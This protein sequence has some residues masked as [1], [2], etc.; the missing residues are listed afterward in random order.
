VNA[1]SGPMMTTTGAARDALA[2]SIASLGSISLDEVLS[3]AKLQTRQERK[4]L[5]PSGAFSVL[6]SALT[7]RLVALEIERRR[8]FSYESVYF[9][10]D[11][12]ALFRQHVQG[13]R[14]RYKVRTRTYLDSGECLV[15]VKVK[16]G[17]G[18]TDKARRPY[19]LADRDRL[20]AP[21]RAFV[22]QTLAEAHG[23]TAPALRAGLVTRYQRATLVDVLAGTRMTC[24]VDLRFSGRTA[25][26][27]GP[28]A[29]LVEV[30]SARND[31][32][33]DRVLRRLGIRPLSISKYCVGVALTDPAQR[34]NPWHRVL[35]RSFPS[36]SARDRCCWGAQ[37]VSVPS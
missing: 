22:D 12:L 21:A 30:K 29:I 25:V 31:S 20:T 5:V 7:P 34:A 2:G 27:D 15:E 28:D 3:A 11:D 36:A 14:R 6:V 32:D 37:R 1:M 16:G 19:E 4:Y 10:T 8:L 26:C 24:D 17:R 33:A 35:R 23:I 13:R 9:D 18:S